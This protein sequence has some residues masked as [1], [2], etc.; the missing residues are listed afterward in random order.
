MAT[1]LPEEEKEELGM[2]TNN[3]TDLHRVL[4]YIITVMVIKEDNGG[5]E[6]PCDTFASENLIHKHI[7]T[8]QFV[9]GNSRCVL[10]YTINRVSYKGNLDSEVF[11][12]H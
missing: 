11:L 4:S 2:T 8:L 9:I 1:A 12:S 7:Y 3:I 5:S 10:Y 6:L